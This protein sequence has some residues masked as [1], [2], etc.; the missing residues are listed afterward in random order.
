MTTVSAPGG[1]D[2]AGEDGPPRPVRSRHDVACRQTIRR[3]ASMPCR[4]RLPRSAKRIRPSIHRRIVV[5]G[6]G[7]GRDDVFGQD[8]V[9]REAH[10]DALGRGHR[11]AGIVGSARAPGRRP[12]S[13]DRSRR[14]TM[15]RA[16]SCG[17]VIGIP[18]S[19]KRDFKAERRPLER[20]PGH[21]SDGQHQRHRQ[22][23]EAGNGSMSGMRS[24]S[25]CSIGN[26]YT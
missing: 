20:M 5:A 6:Y 11:C 8:P 9:Q 16:G 12:S 15:L 14:R 22:R 4:R 2:A 25:V 19:A 18:G 26:A 24:T 10:V 13:S 21:G 7:D 1:H 3:P 23:E 17:A